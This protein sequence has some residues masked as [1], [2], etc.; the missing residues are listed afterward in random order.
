LDN[1]HEIKVFV[2]G[3]CKL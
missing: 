1:F 2:K 3:L